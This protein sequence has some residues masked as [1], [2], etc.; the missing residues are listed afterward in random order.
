MDP[1][2]ALSAI[3]FGIA[4]AGFFNH[5]NIIENLDDDNKHDL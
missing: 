1:L 4:L 3:C 5:F 2:L